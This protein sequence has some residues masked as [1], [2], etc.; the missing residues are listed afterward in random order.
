MTNQE[1]IS[2]VCPIFNN[3]G[4]AYYFTP[5]TGARGAELGF[6]GG[7]FYFAG[8]GGVLGNCDA[9]VVASAFGY[10]NPAVVRRNWES[11]CAKV[12]PRDAGA[13]HWECC[14]VTGRAKLA[15]LT[16]AAAFVDAAEAVFN[17]AD[18]DG[19]ALFAGFKTL[20]LAEDLPARAL[21]LVAAL[22]EFRGSAHLVA[23]RAVGLTSKQAHYLKRP[24]DMKMFGYAPDDA[25]EVPANGHEL[26]ERAEQL[27][28]Q[29]VTPAYAILNDSQRAALVS[30]AQQVLAALSA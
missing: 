3:T 16:D 7:E 20:P 23:V 29:I 12:A 15:G 9:N 14:A 2:I 4:F 28:D 24:N 21:Q 17:A 1:L 5:E 19:L 10:F 25:P 22:R 27:T 30:G 6:Q 13:A 11:A 18:S 26:M 8:R